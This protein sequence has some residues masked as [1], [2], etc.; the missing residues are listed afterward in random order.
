MGKSKGPAQAAGKDDKKRKGRGSDE[1]V[2]EKEKGVDSMEVR[3][4]LVE[5]HGKAMEI[6]EKINMGALTFNEAAREYSIDKAGRSGLLGWKR[7]TELDPDFWEAALTVAVG[8][9]TREPIKTQYGYH[10]IMV[11]ARK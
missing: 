4:I 9:Y 2:E 11:Q 10:I 8:D 3:H 5:K 6:L 1:K 7:R